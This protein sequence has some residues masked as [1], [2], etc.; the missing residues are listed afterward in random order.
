MKLYLQFQ[1]ERLGMAL[2]N[3]RAFDRCISD[4]VDY[5][6]QREVRGKRILDNQAVYFRLAELA[7]EVESLRAI[8]YKAVGK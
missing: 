5:T 4:T 7:T 6:R 3:L 1:E 2:V 8:T